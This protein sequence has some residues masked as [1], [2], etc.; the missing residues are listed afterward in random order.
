[1]DRSNCDNIYCCNITKSHKYVVQFFI[2]GSG[3]NQSIQ[4]FRYTVECFSK[5]CL[6]KAWWSQI[7]IHSRTES[8]RSTL[9][10][11]F[12]QCCLHQACY[13]FY[14]IRSTGSIARLRCYREKMP[15][16]S[17]FTSSLRLLDPTLYFCVCFCINSFIGALL[18]TLCDGKVCVCLCWVI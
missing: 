1:M 13:L 17:M 5:T 4:R 8:K 18:C 2:Q 14:S 9:L 3:W 6:N 7:Q 11:L 10:P 12:L 15:S 16:I